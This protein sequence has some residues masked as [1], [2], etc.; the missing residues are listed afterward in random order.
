MAV[1][2]ATLE[3]WA[4]SGVT[5]LAAFSLFFGLGHYP[6]LDNNE[7]LYAQIARE[8]VRGGSLIIPHLN[9]VPYIEKPP[10]LYWLTAAAYVGFGIYEFAARL[11][12]AIAGFAVCI[13][14]GAFV[15]RVNPGAAGPIGAAIL[16]SSIVFV[17]M[18]R[19]IIFDVL[20]TLWVTMAILCFFLWHR[21]R[22]RL[23]VRLCYL[24][25]GLG[26]LTKG[27]V[28]AVLVAITV[29]PFAAY[30]RTIRD[31]IRAFLDPLGLIV[32][33]A[34]V[35]PWHV[36]A[37]I[38][39]PAFLRVYVLGEHVG[40]FFGTR[41]PHDYH[42]GGPFYYVPRI[43]LYLL[44]WTLLV[45]ALLWRRGG[46]T[47]LDALCWIWVVSH[48]VF[49]SIAFNKANYYLITVAPALTI[50]FALKLAELCRQRRGFGLRMFAAAWLSALVVA[51][52]VVATRCEQWRACVVVSDPGTQFSF[53]AAVFIL[54]IA[55]VLAARFPL[56][57]IAGV[58]STIFPLM[59]VALRVMQ[60]DAARHSQKGVV[61]A[62][63]R[64]DPDQP[65]AL[66]RDYESLSTIGFY[67]GRR[68]PVI[69]SRSADL[70]FGSRDPA[71]TGW[72]PSAAEFSRSAQTQA[73]FVVVRLR[74]SALFV[75]SAPAV[76]WC[77]VVKSP[78]VIAY[79]NVPEQCA[80][81]T[82]ID[83][84]GG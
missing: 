5:A 45:P 35:L 64:I 36:A 6:L 49:F 18:S 21:E 43:I 71:A 48:A 26:I 51:A 37:A 38:E 70:L 81:L 34:V 46:K 31:T 75:A 33:S 11:P 59:F 66:F 67:A 69:A 82:V 58:A 32:L 63:N 19:T 79:S 56:L 7:G 78:R 12:V 39:N 13:V 27:P 73:F 8:M 30:T 40:R 20:L 50:L 22:R 57:A 14:T 28:A 9:G 29:L 17:A 74:N 72:F 2:P 52:I 44:P 16:A 83:G 15:R 62:L 84:P 60:V 23:W 68:V 47:N 77:P 41:E 24:A 55:V 53:A 61:E 4:W 42:T 76:A 25:I 65:I 10:L 54:G 3:A 1:R 80:R